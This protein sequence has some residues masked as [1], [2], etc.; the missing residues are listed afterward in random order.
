MFGFKQ[1]LLTRFNNNFRAFNE[2]IKI[3]EPSSTSIKK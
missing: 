2:A 1:K 3:S